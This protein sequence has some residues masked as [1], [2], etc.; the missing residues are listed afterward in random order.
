MSIIFVLFNIV[1]SRARGARW[2]S[3]WIA[4]QY[5]RGYKSP[6]E[7]ARTGGGLHRRETRER[8]GG[9]RDKNVFVGVSVRILR[10][11]DNYIPRVVPRCSSLRV[12]RLSSSC[13][14][15]RPI[16][17]PSLAVPPDDPSS[18]LPYPPPA[19]EN[20][21]TRDAGRS[22]ARSK[23][24]PLR[25]RHFNTSPSC[26]RRAWPRIPLLISREEG[27]TSWRFNLYPQSKFTGR[28]SRFTVCIGRCR[29]TSREISIMN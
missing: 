8:T 5:R 9:N 6:I 2:S 1:K 7:R 13:S 20:F 21:D 28:P 25:A 18:L 12:S 29:I 24:H 27:V 23:L 3:M 22:L 19:P 4:L 17:I 15:A 16:Y 14:P 26:P 11:S 10:R